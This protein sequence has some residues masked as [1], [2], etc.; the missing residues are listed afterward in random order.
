MVFVKKIEAYEDKSGNKIFFSGNPITENISIL[1][2]GSNNT[3]IIE[4]GARLRRLS[5]R[6]DQDNGTLRIGKNDGKVAPFQAIIRIGQDATVN[7][8]KNVS[9]TNP[10]QISAVEGTTV[11][12]GDD[13]MIAGDVKLRGD[14]GHPIF[15]VRT[16]KRV[17]TAKNITIGNHVWL[18]LESILLGGASLGEGSVVGAR[19]VV[20]KPFPNNCIV[21]G[22]PAKIVRRNIAWERPHLSLTNPPYKNSGD[23]IEKTDYWNM[24]VDL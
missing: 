6:F 10:V 20:T 4:E 12:L 5:V 19:A 7:V 1:F 11:S 9:A 14:D 16:N 8:G 3:L 18:G 23:D 21:A 15:D 2:R 17:N 22:V 13:V 24:T